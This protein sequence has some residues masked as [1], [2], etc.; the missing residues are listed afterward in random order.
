M[1]LNSLKHF[2]TIHR[3]RDRQMI[4]A[5]AACASYIVKRSAAEGTK[6]TYLLRGFAVSFFTYLPDV[7][8]YCVSTVFFLD[9][10]TNNVRMWPTNVSFQHTPQSSISSPHSCFQNGDK[11]SSLQW[12]IDP[13]GLKSIFAP[14]PQR[15]LAR[16]RVD[17]ISS[18]MLINSHSA[19]KIA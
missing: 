16:V 14:Y 3:Q 8:M 9:N 19:T 4:I 7:P 10:M 17:K 12:S 1:I 6:I 11:Q 2:D 18:R 13:T 15:D 5:H